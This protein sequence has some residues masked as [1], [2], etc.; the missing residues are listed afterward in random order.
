MS[1]FR[2]GACLP[3]AARRRNLK[4]DDPRQIQ[5]DQRVEKRSAACYHVIICT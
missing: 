3:H 5:A 2:W 4:P 1:K